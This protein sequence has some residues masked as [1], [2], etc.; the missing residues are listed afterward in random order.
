MDF[1]FFVTLRSSKIQFKNRVYNISEIIRCL[2]FLNYY[3]VKVNRSQEIHI[4]YILVIW[5][6]QFIQ[7]II[8]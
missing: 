6:I 7:Y 4:A 5:S 8:L 3:T 2:L 1:S